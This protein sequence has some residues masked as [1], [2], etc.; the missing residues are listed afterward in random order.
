[1]NKPIIALDFPTKVAVEQFLSRFE[2]KSL[3]LKVGMQ[4]FYKEGPSMIDMLKAAGHWVFLDL[5]LHDIPNTVKEA[6]RNLASLQVDMVNVHASGGTAMMEA[7]LE[8]LELGLTR[9][10]KRPLCIAVT[11]LTSTS[12][13]MLKRELLIHK[14]MEKTVLHYATL[15]KQ[16]GL[17]GVVCSALEVPTLKRE[18]DDVVTVTPGIR[19]SG[20]DKGDQSRTVTPE[21]AK[22]L[23]SDYIVVG[24][25]IT[26]SNN[27]LAAYERVI[28]EWQII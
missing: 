4:L 14:G 25:S 21:K 7:A 8:G 27:P 11:Q 16:S 2:G 23:G 5:K 18:L 22:Q 13:Q 24:R 17:D 1:M 9:G 3:N 26:A 20:D 10:Q 15:V 6:M 19:L 28:S 12:E